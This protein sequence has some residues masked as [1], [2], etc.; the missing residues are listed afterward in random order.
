[1]DKKILGAVYD[2][3]WNLVIDA[4]RGRVLSTAILQYIAVGEIQEL[5]DEDLNNALEAIIII[6]GSE[7]K[8]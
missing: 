2:L 3:I 5:H 1:M 6:L 4:E 8:W 7:K